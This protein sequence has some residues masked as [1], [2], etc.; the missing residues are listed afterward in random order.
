MRPLSIK[1]LQGAKV[2]SRLFGQPTQRK[3]LT[4]QAKQSVS[5]TELAQLPARPLSGIQDLD[6]ASPTFGK[7]WY[8][9][10]Y[11][12]IGDPNHPLGP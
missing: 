12:E 2:V 5:H 10:G 3:F 1:R 4:N 8:L 9:A 7:F 11:D 6:P